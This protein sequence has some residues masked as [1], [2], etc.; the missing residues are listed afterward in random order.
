MAASIDQG[1]KTTLAVTAL[2]V[3][4]FLSGAAWINNSIGAVERSQ[5]QTNSALEMI[6]YRLKTLEARAGADAGDKWTR[7]DMRAWVREYRASNPQNPP[8]PVD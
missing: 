2:C 1:T 5:L 6:D 8:P 7:S 3:S 4:A